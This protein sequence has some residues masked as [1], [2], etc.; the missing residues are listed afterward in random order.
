MGDRDYIV[1]KGGKTLGEIAKNF[2]LK[3]ALLSSYSGFSKDHNFEQGDKLQIPGKGYQLGQAW[4][5]MDQE[6]FDSL[7]VQGYFM[8]NLDPNFFEKVYCTSWGK[9]YKILSN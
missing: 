1:P 4:F 2:A 3:E 8:E 6:A 5:F 9:V 7:L